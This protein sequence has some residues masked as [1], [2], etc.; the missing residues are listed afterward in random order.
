MSA[1]DKPNSCPLGQVKTTKAVTIPAGSRAMIDGLTCAASA[2]CMKISV[3]ETPGGLIL[4]LGLRFLKPASSVER[5]VVEVSN[6]P[7]NAVTLP[8]KSC[9]CELHYVDVVP[10]EERVVDYKRHS[11]DFCDKFLESLQTNLQSD[12]VQD[13][14]K[15]IGRYADVFSQHDMDLGHAKSVTHRICLTDDTPFEEGS[16]RIPLDMIEDV[17]KHLQEM[18]DL[19]VIRRLNSPYASNIVLVKKKD[20]SLCFSIDLRRLNSVTIRDAYSLPR[21]NESPDALGGARWFFTLDLKSAYWQV[22]LEEE[23]KE[24]TAFEAG[25]LGFWKCNA[26][27]FGCTNAP[28]TFHRLIECCMG[29]LYPSSCLL[30]LDDIVVFSNTYEEHIE[31]LEAIF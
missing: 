14:W 30:Y 29:D 26:M 11:E 9:L 16:R 21:I 19:G 27:P 12:Q 3:L 5:V 20:G 18:A 13:V 25:A 1:Q 22:E 28:G 2:T 15:M 8:A 10:P 17:R 7:G 31:K 4:T 23:N 6:F 24:K